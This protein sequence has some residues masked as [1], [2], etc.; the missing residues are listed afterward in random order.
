MSCIEKPRIGVSFDDALCAFFIT[1]RPL[2]WPTQEP[3]QPRIVGKIRGIAALVKAPTDSWFLALL[4][5]R[6]GKYRH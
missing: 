2:T 4:S 5:A 6:L 3:R 1:T